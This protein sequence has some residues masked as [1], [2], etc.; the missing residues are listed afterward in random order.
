MKI[1]VTILFSLIGLFLVAQQPVIQGTIIYK[2]DTID[3]K[4]FIRIPQEPPVTDP[5]Q[6]PTSA[7]NAVGKR[8]YLTPASWGGV[9][10]NGKSYKVNPGDTFVLSAKHNVQGLDIENFHGTET[11][12]IVIINEGDAKMSAGIKLSH[13]T[14]IKITGSG[15]G[16]KYGIDVTGNGTGVGIEVRGRSANIEIERVNVWKKAYGVWVKE[17]ANCA[18]SLQYPNW[19]MD[20]ISLHD[21][22][23]ANIGQDGLYFGSTSP[24][25]QRT[26]SCNG[27]TITPI[28]LRLS[29][30]RI[31]N[32]IVDSCNRT[33]IQLSG[34]DQ[35]KNEI[36]NNIVTRCGYE[37]NN[38]Q[39][40]GI[41][42]GGM[43]TAR[44]YKNL[45][46]STYKH[47]IFCLG[48]G[49][50]EIS[51]N[52]IDHSGYLGKLV[53]TYLQPAGILADTRGTVPA[54][55][56]TTL[57][58]KENILGKNAVKNGEH[59]VIFNSGNSYTDSNIIRN[60]KTVSGA[61]AKIYV[62]PGVKTV[63]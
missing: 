27:K 35:G 55:L 51:N 21:C 59:I 23:F 12:P 5:P 33:G 47:G 29:N 49:L 18:D 2:G 48:V 10:L 16:S 14:N 44:V 45:V 20:N 15:N 43:T 19:R 6:P 56:T 57:V 37:L 24:T 13:C 22:R 28:P 39:G 52:I 7:C 3:F 60:N 36:Y 11:C 1:I 40:D 50:C 34:A 38:T 46:D 8:I 25:G 26:V 61:E 9:Y 31:Y 41:A 32:N 30:I 17:E 62:A 4:G 54:G 58:I 53:N 42:L 63:Q